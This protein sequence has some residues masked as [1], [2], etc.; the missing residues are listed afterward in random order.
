MNTHKEKIMQPVY[1][2]HFTLIELLITIAI[3]AI[4]AAMLLPSLNQARDK[5]KQAGCSNNLKQMGLALANY[6]TDYD[7]YFPAAPE[8]VDNAGREAFTGLC[9]Y[10]N[11]RDGMDY[12]PWKYPSYDYASPVFKCPNTT[13]DQAKNQYGWNTYNGTGDKYTLP[14]YKKI[15]QIKKPTQII[16]IADSDHWNLGYWDYADPIGKGYIRFRHKFKANTL[17][18]DGHAEQR[19]VVNLKA[20]NFW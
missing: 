9:P 14:E 2:Q 3:I 5:A 19:G 1:N 16:N 20:E 4:L 17:M 7:D 13:T 15:N 11:V 12:R 8:Y 18:G 10:L 6:F